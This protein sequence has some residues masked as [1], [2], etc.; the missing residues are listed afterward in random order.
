MPIT[1]DVVPL[2]EELDAHPELWNDYKGRLNNPASPHRD[3]DD[4]WLRFAKDNLDDK[5]H[6]VDGPHES[7]WFPA[8]ETLPAAKSLAIRMFE[9]TGASQLGGVLI[10]RVPPG[11][12]IYPHVDRAWHA[13]HYEK[14]AVQISGNEQQQFA[15][16]DGAL[17][18]KSGESY[19]LDN[20]FPHWV[21]NPT[22]DPWINMTVCY[23]R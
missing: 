22:P 4:I 2:A 21:T 5:D 9:M 16:E 23:R 15:F 14:F 20:Y 1:F 3:S 7:V 6:K 18:A 17:S 19:W 8:S 13:M 12:Q 11:K 10:I